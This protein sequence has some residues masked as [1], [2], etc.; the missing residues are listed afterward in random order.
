VATAVDHYATPILRLVK[1]DEIKFEL[2][3]PKAD[4]RLDSTDAELRFDN[5]RDM[6]GPIYA[7]TDIWVA[8]GVI[9]P[10]AMKSPF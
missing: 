4:L 10:V 7:F 3:L 2:H 6:K 8:R 1:L 9:D 5:L